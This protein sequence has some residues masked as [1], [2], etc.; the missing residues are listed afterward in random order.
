MDPFTSDPFVPVDCFTER[1]IS[2][3]RTATTE[4]NESNDPFLGD[5]CEKDWSH[6][7][8]CSKMFPFASS[9]A[10]AAAKMDDSW[11]AF[12][13]KATQV[14]FFNKLLALK[15]DITISNVSHIRHQF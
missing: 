14:S 15:S 6:I 7:F 2:A 5:E 9:G 8:G 11:Y 12:Q 1:S 13:N 3:K 10:G 4:E